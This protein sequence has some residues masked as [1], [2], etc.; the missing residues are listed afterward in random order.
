MTRLHGTAAA[1][2]AG[3]LLV[4]CS[5]G[6]SPARYEFT[7]ERPATQP[8][9]DPTS[10]DRSCVDPALVSPSLNSSHYIVVSRRPGDAVAI[11]HCLLRLRGYK[12]GP[13]VRTDTEIPGGGYVGR[14]G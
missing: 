7:V 11:A 12:V 10:Q 13:I 5:G 3:L 2:A 8:I 14:G 1:V 4:G 9:Y 6:K